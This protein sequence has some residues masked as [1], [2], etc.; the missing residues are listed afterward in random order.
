M[1]AKI[2]DKLG[3]KILR[4]EKNATSIIIDASKA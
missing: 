3:Y 1:F 2:V 4:K